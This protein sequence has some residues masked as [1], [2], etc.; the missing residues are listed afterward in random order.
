MEE[1][2]REKGEKGK[3]KGEIID[4]F[5]LMIDDWKEKVGPIGP[6]GRVGQVG[7]IL[8]Q[9]FRLRHD[10]DETKRRDKPTR[11][12]KGRGENC[13]LANGY[14]AKPAISTAVSAWL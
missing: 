5:R 13:K 11:Q 14:C 9:G 7:P 3:G 12:A 2:Y 10:F 8:R 6:V 1:L 4:D